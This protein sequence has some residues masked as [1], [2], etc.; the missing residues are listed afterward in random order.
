[1]P[2]QKQSGGVNIS[3]TGHVNVGG[4]IVGRDKYVNYK[5]E[6]PPTPKIGCIGRTFFVA[7]FFLIAGAVG[8]AFGGLIGAAVSGALGGS[9]AAGAG[10]AIGAVLLGLFCAIG[11]SSIALGS[12]RTGK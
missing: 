3:G 12:M 11:A 4:D 2:K 10:G 7:V 5:L 6:G 9:N 1:M 8:A